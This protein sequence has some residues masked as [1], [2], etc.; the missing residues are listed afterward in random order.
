ML[1]IRK[2]CDVERSG[3]GG[4]QDGSPSDETLAQLQ[5]QVASYLKRTWSLDEVEENIE[6][7]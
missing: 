2:T 5:E 4:W 6:P 7:R 3:E 1:R